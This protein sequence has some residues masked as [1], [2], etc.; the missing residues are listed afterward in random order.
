[1][2]RSAAFRFA[3]GKSLLAIVGVAVL[4]LAPQIAMAQHAAG[5]HAGGGA[6]AGAS[7]QFSSPPAPHYSAPPAP[8]P[9]YSPPPPAPAPHFSPPP[10]V[11]T[12]PTAFVPPPAAY[13]PPP[14]APAGNNAVVHPAPVMNTPAQLFSTTPDA[15][16]AWSGQP[17][18]FFGEGH[19]IYSEPAGVIANSSTA[20]VAAT[21]AA[22]TTAR[23]PFPGPA[24]FASPSATL[25]AP[26]HIFPPHRRV[27]P[28]VVYPGFGTFG[29]GGFGFGTPFFG[30]PF[31]YGDPFFF[32]DPF[33]GFEFGSVFE[34]CNGFGAGF[35]CMPYNSNYYYE[36]PF[37]STMIGGTETETQSQEIFSPYSPA[38]PQPEENTNGPSP[39]EY[40]LYLKDGAVYVVNDYW[41]ADGKLVYSTASGQDSVDLARIDLQKTLDVNA[42]RGLVFTL[43]PAPQAAPDATPPQPDQAP[44]P[45]QNAPP[46]SPQP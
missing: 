25:G 32:G 10:H 13:V 20:S 14:A 1:M 21:G 22:A 29:F 44:P 7:P 37:T 12:P 45:D 43:R 3:P 6:S 36:Q 18:R 2:K 4:A 46:P 30:S 23:R 19:Q 17:L 41:Y 42:Q 35:Q 16:R 8:A 38:L 11:V 40:V 9:H 34:P 24:E 5:G 31:Y 27:P 33:F 15:M 28:I 39:D 26:P